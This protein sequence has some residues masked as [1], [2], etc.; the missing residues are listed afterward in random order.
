MC[1]RAWCIGCQ[2]ESLGPAQ[3]G[4]WVVEEQALRIEVQD[5]GHYT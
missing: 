5:V 1:G 3:E 2:D 4:C